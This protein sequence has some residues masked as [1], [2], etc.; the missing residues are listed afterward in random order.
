MSA[1]TNNL[2][3][4]YEALIN[5][6]L[7]WPGLVGGGTPL[8][9]TG[10]IIKFDVPAKRWPD[11]YKSMRQ[12]ADAPEVK[13]EI[14]NVRADPTAPRTFCTQPSRSIATFE[15]TVTVADKLYNLLTQVTSELRACYFASGLQLG[16]SAMVHHWEWE[17]RPGKPSVKERQMVFSMRVWL[18]S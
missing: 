15:I 6:A 11:F 8:V 4:T 14:A 9:R 3:A 10:N 18:K 12:V 7:A 16:Q 2:F 1:A 13:F 5:L 17:I